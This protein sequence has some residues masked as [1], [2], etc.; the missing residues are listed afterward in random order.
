[1]E[2]KLEAQEV[3]PNSHLGETLRYEL[4]H[5]EPLTLFLRVPAAPLDNNLCERA[6]K[7]AIRHRT[8]SLFYKTEKGAHV[9]DLFMSLIH[10]CRLSRINPF[11]DLTTLRKY[12]HKLRDGPAAWMPWTYQA[13]VA[14]LAQP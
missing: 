6:L 13:T 8:N 1:M 12:A 4:K 11:D 9:G 5:G 14:A 7:M 3:E 2:R 10:T